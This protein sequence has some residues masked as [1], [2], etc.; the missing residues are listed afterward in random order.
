MT[1]DVHAPELPKTA[2]A[3]KPEPKKAD[4]K[5]PYH[6]GVALGV[7]TSVYAISLLATTRIQID[8]D[9]GLIA[10][11]LP[12]Q[13]AIDIL[14]DHHDWL[15]ERLGEARTQY[16]A[17]VDGYDALSD[18]LGTLE[19]RIGAL[20]QSIATVERLGNS[21]SLHLSLPRLTTGKGGSVAATGGGGGT[22]GS[23][24]NGGGTTK[25]PAVAP[26]A[27]PPPPT[28]GGTGASGG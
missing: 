18:R 11:R 4:P 22:S 6:V 26:P 8:T 1:M 25:P 20:D 3:K 12:V 14:A 16:A 23:G 5:R 17:G 13:R 9:R 21:L 7:T 19:A 28:S 24:G 10:D 27:P 15:D 2:A